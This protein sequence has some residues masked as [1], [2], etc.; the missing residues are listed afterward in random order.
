MDRTLG[1]CGGMGSMDRG[2]DR[3]QA[4]TLDAGLSRM[5]LS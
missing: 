2:G 1:A 5:N 4:G 3:Y